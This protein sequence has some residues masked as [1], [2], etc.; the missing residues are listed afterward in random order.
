MAEIVWGCGAASYANGNGTPDTTFAPKEATSAQSVGPYISLSAGNLRSFGVTSQN[1]VYTWGEE[2]KIPTLVETINFP[3]RAVVQHY[4]APFGCVLGVDGSVWS[5][6]KSDDFMT[7][8]ATE[9]PVNLKVGGPLRLEGFD[10]RVV[11]VSLGAKHSAALTEKGTVYTWGIGP[12]ISVDPASPMPYHATPEAVSLPS[13]ATD[14]AVGDGFTLVC[15][16]DG[17][18]YTWGDLAESE[19]WQP[20]IVTFLGTATIKVV[21]VSA[22]E[23]HAMV[24][25]DGGFIYTWGSNENGEIGSGPADKDIKKAPFKLPLTDVAVIKSFKNSNF[26]ITIRG[27]LFAWGSNV[28]GHLGIGHINAVTQPTHVNAARPEN[29][30]MQRGSSSY[31]S[32]LANYKIVDVTSGFNHTLFSVAP[33]NSTVPI[34]PSV[35][36]FEGEPQPYPLPPPPSVDLPKGQ[37]WTTGSIAATGCEPSDEVVLWRPSPQ[38]NGKSVV[39][40]A[41]TARVGWTV[42]SDGVMF[43]WGTGNLGTGEDSQTSSNPTRLWDLDGHKIASVYA[44]P[45]GDWAMCI[46]DKGKVYAWGDGQDFRTGLGGVQRS[47]FPKMV[48]FPSPV[49]CLALGHTHGI[50]VTEDYG[51]WTWG[52]GKGLGNGGRTKVERSPK[53][54]QGAET[55]GVCHVT[56]GK[57][58]STMLTLSGEVFSWGDAADGKL[59]HEDG[60]EKVSPILMTTFPDDLQV[61]HVVSGLQFSLALMENGSIYSWGYGA[62]GCLGFGPKDLTTKNIPTKIPFFDTVGKMAYL[63]ASASNSVFAISSLGGLYAWGAPHLGVGTG[64]TLATPTRVATLQKYNVQGVAPGEWQSLAWMGSLNTPPPVAPVLVGPWGPVPTEKTPEEDDEDSTP[65]IEI[66][67]TSTPEPNG[68]NSPKVDRPVSARLNLK[69]DPKRHSIGPPPPESGKLAKHNQALDSVNYIHKFFLDE[70]ELD[71]VAQLGNIDEVR[72]FLDVKGYDPSHAHAQAI[73]TCCAQ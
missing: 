26:A 24:L 58:F 61:V 11:K 53:R 41:T 10:S 55:L 42:L 49:K 3:A 27:D 44:G 59:G 47:Q 34:V 18:A 1:K 72:K 21:A 40:G 7:G 57:G 19:E 30:T 71:R 63:I 69:L 52:T 13:A 5:W 68:N 14:I 48:E 31:S 51:V 37:M 64:R 16:K 17:N 50:A 70:P 56:A 12:G 67:R 39:S 43:A 32:P 62:D 36:A 20:K 45:T 2:D 23:R 6:G 35:F 60:A 66:T 8:L 38:W 4:E 28:W 25:T 33:K 22:G 15:C 65:A 73:K 54:I 46:T 29:G 9:L